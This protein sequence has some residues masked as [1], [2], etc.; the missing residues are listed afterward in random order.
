MSTI[1]LTFFDPP[2]LTRRWVVVLI[3]A[4]ISAPSISVAAQS[5]H[6]S[7]ENARPPGESRGPLQR[8]IAEHG[9]HFLVAVAAD[10][11]TKTYSDEVGPSE[12]P[13][14]FASP[15]AIDTR[16]RREISGPAK[17][18]GYVEN[19]GLETLRLLVPAALV[20][21]D[22]GD[23]GA[24]ARDLAGYAE[25]YFMKRAVVRFAK[26]VVGRERPALEFAAEDGHG[27]RKT[28]TLEEKD[29]NHQSFPSGHASGSFAWAGYLERAL[30]RELGMR[31]PARAVSFGALY[32][33]AGWISW[34]RMRR[35]KHYASDVLAGAAIGVMMSRASYR[36][37]HPEE[38]P[39][40]RAGRSARRG[41]HLEPP[42]L[43]PGGGAL[44]VGVRLGRA[45]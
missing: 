45:P 24:M 10:F 1:L 38:Y 11:L 7:D 21:L 27:P 13:L 34:S 40:S 36:L 25:L 23:G 19:N 33:V 17:E 35:D 14:L 4:A 32:G 5:D 12:D 44:T 37:N 31:T 22:F 6:P 18:R 39:E 29:G 42:T 8:F 9:M 26:D 41:I 20:G 28:A 16:L 3:L 43:L 2:G 15:G 30:A